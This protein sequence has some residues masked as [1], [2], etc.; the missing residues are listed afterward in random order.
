MK[1]QNRPPSGCEVVGK[2]PAW[3][4]WADAVAKTQQR[5][6]ELLAMGCFTIQD[7]ATKTGWTLARCKNFLNRNRLKSELS[8]DPREYN[9]PRVRFFFPPGVKP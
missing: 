1:R 3:E 2:K 7:F 9:N 4:L 8:N 5:G 6:P